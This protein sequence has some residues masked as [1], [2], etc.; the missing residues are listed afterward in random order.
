MPEKYVCLNCTHIWVSRS[1][2]VLERQ[3]SVCRRRMATSIKELEK[4]VLTV[5]EWIDVRKEHIIP[6]APLYFP[7]AFRSAI[8]LI[9]KINPE[10]PYGLE[11]LRK[12]YVIASEYNPS[13][14]NIEECIVRL[15]TEGKL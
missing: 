13:R 3:C 8:R 9:R 6:I 5:K 7:P 14:E 1:E 10:F 4:V 12:I 2:Q 11:I 15:R